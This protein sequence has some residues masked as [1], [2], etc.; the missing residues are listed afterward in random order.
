MS[1]PKHQLPWFSDNLKRLLRQ[2][3][4]L[5]NK[6]KLTN[7]WSRYRTHQKLCKVQMKRSEQDYI[8]NT[9]IDG[10][11]NDNNKP[12]WKYIKSKRRDNV[13]ISPLKQNGSLVC[14]ASRKAEILLN[15]FS[16]VF[17]TET[18]GGVYPYPR[19]DLT[20]LPPLV[21]TSNG[22]TKLLENINIT[23]ASGPDNLPNIYLKACAQQLAPGLSQIFAKSVITGQLPED[24]RDAIVAPIFKKGN[25]HLAE[26]YRPVS[27]TSVISKLLEH[28]ICKHILDHLDRNNILTDLNHGFRKGFSC[29]TQLL[30][31]MDDLLEQYDNNI[32]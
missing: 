18:T 13:G 16:S 5:Y 19:R 24:W 14:E 23:K 1:R 10:M 9:I 3:Q 25:V 20:S 26:N 12:F 6:A 4:K 30:V 28:I 31:T 17:N 15:Q 27:L 32:N 22:V 29:E 8:N 2:K 11:A 7:D 21:I